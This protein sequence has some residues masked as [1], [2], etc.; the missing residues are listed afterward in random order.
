MPNSCWHN[1]FSQHDHQISATGGEM[2]M[3]LLLVIIVAALVSAGTIQRSH[4]ETLLEK[5]AQV[6]SPSTN[7]SFERFYFNL[8]GT[9]ID[10][11]EPVPLWRMDIRSFSSTD[12]V[13]FYFLARMA[14]LGWLRPLLR[15][16]S[17]YSCD[18]DQLR[19]QSVFVAGFEDPVWCEQLQWDAARWLLSQVNDR[20]LQFKPDLVQKLFLLMHTVGIDF[21][22]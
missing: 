11:G 2:K 1:E 14:T 10:Q 21:P 15:D 22:H 17:P 20:T 16:R 4:S 3:K 19:L 18:A 6:T 12:Q 7:A 5:V 9:L 8:L 13:H